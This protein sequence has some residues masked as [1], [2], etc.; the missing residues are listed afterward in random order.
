VHCKPGE[1]PGECIG[2]ISF[3][4]AA[5]Q[6]VRAMEIMRAAGVLRVIGEDTP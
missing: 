1:E 5:E 3:L 6:K 2:E 4:T